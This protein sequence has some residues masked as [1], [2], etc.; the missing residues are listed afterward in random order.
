VRRAFDA[1]EMKERRISGIDQT[2]FHEE[3]PFTRNDPECESKPE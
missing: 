2:C 3:H 1:E